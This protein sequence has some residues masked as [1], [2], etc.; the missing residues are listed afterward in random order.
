MIVALT[1]Y[2][3]VCLLVNDEAEEREAISR[4]NEA[5]AALDKIRKERPAGVV[6]PRDLHPWD[7]NGLV[8]M[9]ESTFRFAL[10]WVSDAVRQH[11][12]EWPTT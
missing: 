9:P 4:S 7:A 5:G 1:P 8:L 6:Q 2:E 11:Y 10:Q 12:E 3:Q